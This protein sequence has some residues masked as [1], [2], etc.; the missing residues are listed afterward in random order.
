M[1]V[2][3]TL[4]LKAVRDLILTQIIFYNNLLKVFFLADIDSKKIKVNTAET[5]KNEEV[6]E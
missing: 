2:E 3:K 4:I 5:N 6:F 1:K